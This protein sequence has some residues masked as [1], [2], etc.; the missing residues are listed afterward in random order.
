LNEFIPYLKLKV[1]VHFSSP[2]KFFI[3]RRRITSNRAVTLLEDV[4]R[5]MKNSQDKILE[6]GYLPSQILN[7]DETAKRCY[8]ADVRVL[9]QRSN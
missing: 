5:I 3:L 9:T 8:W 6:K 1:M 4:E 7:L 2:T